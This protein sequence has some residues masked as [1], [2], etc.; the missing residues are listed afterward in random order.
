M[1]ARRRSVASRERIALAAI[2]ASLVSLVLL[3]VTT[4]TRAAPAAP[5]VH[6]SSDVTGYA[7]SDH[8]FVVTPSIGGSVAQPSAG[9]SVGGRYLVDV[10]SAASVDIVSTASRRWEE[11]RH[12]GSVDAAYKPGAFGV[13]A[14]A[15]VSSE[16]DY[17]SFSG[18]AA[19]TQDV[20]DKSVTWLLG[21]TYGHDVA[22]RTGTPFSVFSHPLDKG[23]AKAA[24]TLVLGPATIL[25]VGGDVMIESGDSSKVYRYVPM[26]APGTSLPRGA[27][28]GLVTST[29]LSDRPLEQLPSSRDRYALSALLA[30]RF[31]EATLRFDQR[32]YV[33]SWG[34]KA[35]TTDVR[36][37]YD[38]SRRVEI[39]PHVRVHA[40]TSVDFWQRVYVMRPGFDFPALRTGDREL[41]PLVNLT[42]GG[43]IRVG[44]GGDA[45]P[46]SWVL[47][48]D[49]NLTSSQFLDD[50]YITQRTSAIAAVSLEAEL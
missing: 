46:K 24:L 39:G 10:V 30:H 42:G 25:S 21:L 18:G 34:L 47:G 49:L 29:R 15:A 1:T 12:A 20:F 33:D 9:W 6:A 40:Q 37:R 41:G 23:G 36:Y 26:F 31:R 2:A 5:D 45:H 17:Q 16:P 3:L 13:L 27:S 11:V 8:V 14:S 32:V 22:G 19:I 48:F 43:A 4:P 38:L 7:D 28:I 35:T 50:L 44:V